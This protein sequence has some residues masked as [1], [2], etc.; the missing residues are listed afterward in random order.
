MQ[1]LFI[2]AVVCCLGCRAEAEVGAKNIKVSSAELLQTSSFQTLDGESDSDALNNSPRLTVKRQTC[3]P[4][5]VEQRRL[6]ATAKCDSNYVTAVTTPG[7]CVL[8]F[9]ENIGDIRRCGT[10]RGTLCALYNPSL[11]TIDIVNRAQNVERVCFEDNLLS[12]T[13]ANC[14]AECRGAL[15]AFGSDFGCCIRSEPE[16]DAKILT[17]L[18]WSQCGVT[19]PE[20]C[21]DT[22][23]LLPGNDIS[24]GFFCGFSHFIGIECRHIGSKLLQIYEDCGDTE[25]AN[26]LRQQCGF[27]QNG[28]S[29]GV[30]LELITTERDTVFSTYN[31]C[32][33]FLSTRV[34]TIECRDSLEGLKNRFGC[35]VNNLNVT[36]V[37]TDEEIDAFVTSYALWSACGVES[38]GFCN[39]PDDVSM[40][41]DLINCNKC[42]D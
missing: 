29:C 2:V 28:R 38:P 18:L 13:L 41:D 40:Y 22:P 35:C 11:A 10:D 31:K 3:Q 6:V 4:D 15:E 8:P 24:C 37:A 25:S 14:S 26:E 1:T 7:F 19:R 16:L 39:L 27:N 12:D 23:S 9:F 20:P 32:Y 30:S 17:P 42:H 21:E 5:S 36:S 33:K 34:C